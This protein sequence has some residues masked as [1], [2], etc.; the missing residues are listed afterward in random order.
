MKKSSILFRFIVVFGLGAICYL[1]VKSIR[2][3]KIEDNHYV[4]VNDEVGEL[5]RNYLR[6]ESLQE[7]ATVSA[8]IIMEKI[9]KLKNSKED[10][11]NI[12]CVYIK[13]KV[14]HYEGQLAEAVAQYDTLIAFRASHQDDWIDMS[15]GNEDVEEVSALR[16]SAALSLASQENNNLPE[17]YETGIRLKDQ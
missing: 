16:D 15:I 9:D 13:A 5:F 10:I 4:C 1:G 3:D 11:E 7:G 14:A 8:N 17:R 12:N 2:T 6:A